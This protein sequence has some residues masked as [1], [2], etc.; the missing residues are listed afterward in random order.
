MTKTANLNDH[1]QFFPDNSEKDYLIFQEFL[2]IQI[3]VIH[4]FKNCKRSTLIVYTR[5]IN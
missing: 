4:N 2:I 1:L 5:N 3:R